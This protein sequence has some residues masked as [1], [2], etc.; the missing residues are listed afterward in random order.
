MKA[1]LSRLNIDT[2]IVLLVGM[3]ALASTLPAR[4][5]FANIVSYCANIGIVMLFFMH[6][7]RLSRE[8]VLNGVKHWRLHAA[9]GAVTYIIFPIIGIIV[10]SIHIISPDLAKG[11][12]F[13]TLLP[14]TVQSSIA[15]TAMARGNVAGA[16][17]SASFSNLAGIFITPV[18]VALL[19]TGKQGGVS[20]DAM[21]TVVLQL[22]IPFLVGH[23][24]RPWIGAWVSPAYSSGGT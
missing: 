24:I 22:L 21:Q 20:F 16:V 23:F 17:C 4:G 8:A 9:V 19:I 7:A 3:V 13:L 14:S 15:F 18:L 5:L 11:L 6:G 10:S 12:L 2:Y 1:L